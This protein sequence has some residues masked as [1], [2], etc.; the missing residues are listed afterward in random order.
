MNTKLKLPIVVLASFLSV[1]NVQSQLL[2]RVNDT[3]ITVHQNAIVPANS[4]FRI[5]D[6]NKQLTGSFKGGQTISWV[7]A[8][9]NN[10][11]FKKAVKKLDGPKQC[12]IKPCPPNAPAGVVCWDCQ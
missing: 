4:F 11:S 2:T 10:Q 3:T 5:Y 7:N 8:K 6:S 9:T 12:F 1:K